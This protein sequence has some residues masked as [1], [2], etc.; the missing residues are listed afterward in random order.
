MHECPPGPPGEKGEERTSWIATP[1]DEVKMGS[2]GPKV[3][4]GAN[5]RYNK[6]PILK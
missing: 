1:T 2:P 4:V 5:P 3:G 6:V